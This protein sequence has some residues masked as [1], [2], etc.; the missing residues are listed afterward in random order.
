MRVI[1]G[2]ARGLKLLAPPGT[3]VR[4]TPD[5]VREAVFNSLGSL[6]AVVGASVLD[7]FAGSGALGIE[8]LSRGANDCTFCESD[9]RTVAVL[10]ENLA[11]T[12]TAES[13]Q[14]VSGDT[15]ALLA[16]GGPL[17]GIAAVLALADPPYDFD[18]WTELL[19]LVEHTDVQIVVAESDRP[20]EPPPH[21]RELK[22][23]AYGGTVVT[24]L[25]RSSI[26]DSHR[27]DSH[28]LEPEGG[29]PKDPD[30]RLE[31]HP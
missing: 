21:W 12:R 15:M 22:Q 16:P 29:D 1:S 4:P 2:S 27:L 25:Q 9:P 19:E 28:R 24:I 31:N 17:E 5:R 3:S 26:L 18:R 20:V 13:A 7:L 14:V 30:P 10:R 8:A 11:H 6:G 23:R